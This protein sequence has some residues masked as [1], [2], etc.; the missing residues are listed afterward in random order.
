MDESPLSIA[1]VVDRLGSRFG[2][3][4]AYGVALMRE[5]A[6]A[7]HHITVFAREYDPDC[8]LRLPYERIAVGSRWPS[9]I[10][11]WL[12]A[13]RAVRATRGRFDIVHSHMNGWCGDV[14]V[15]HVT[16]VRYRWRVRAMPALRR[17]LSCLSPR[18]RTYLALEARRIA[19][20]PGHRVVAVSQLI[21]HQLGQAY[22]ADPASWPVIA[23]GVAMA[24][25]AD[26]R[27]RHDLRAELGLP[28][29]ATLCLMVARNPM[30]KGL[31]TALRALEQLPDDVH[32][33][34]VGTNR[35][36]R[37]CVAR[38]PEAVAARVHLVAETSRVEPYYR[39]ADIF[40][41]PTLNDSFGMAPLE[42]MSFG[43]PVILSPAPWCGFAQYVEPGISALVLSHPE[44]ADELA[45]S[46]QALRADVALRERLHSGAQ[47]VLEQHS[48]PHVARQFTELYRAI[49]AERASRSAT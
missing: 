16:P 14:E 28:D 48:W 36:A 3:A 4:E 49:L 38:A 37:E 21:A 33:L 30:R 19:V 29:S 6:A 46:V 35:A 17:W 23:P 41:H 1:F 26:G 13:R 32:L 10:R 40:L 2:G 39:A 43:L 15:V 42:A 44:Q 12:F 27:I 45:Q 25:P 31:P 22:D 24:L 7:G 8:D 20:R 34:V 5:L 11:V 9:W 47:G 18:V